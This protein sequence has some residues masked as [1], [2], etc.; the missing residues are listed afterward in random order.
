M[1]KTTLYGFLLCGALLS[2]CGGGG[3]ANTVPPKPITSNPTQSAYV[4]SMAIGSQIP[5]TPGVG[6]VTTLSD[7]SEVANGS[8]DVQASGQMV[9]SSGNYYLYT[10]NTLAATGE[11]YGSAILYSADGTKLDYEI[12]FHGDQVTICT[13]SSTEALCVQ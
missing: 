13:Q 12:V 6:T 1:Q 8:G 2:G 11:K 9:T 3:G 5:S 4:T 7:V 10:V